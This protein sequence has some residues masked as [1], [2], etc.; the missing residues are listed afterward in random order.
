MKRNRFNKW[1]EIGFLFIV[2]GSCIKFSYHLY[3][4]LM[5]IGLTKGAITNV[6]F[7][8]IYNLK[9]ITT[10]EEYEVYILP[11][12]AISILLMI[13]LIELVVSYIKHSIQKKK[14]R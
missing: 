6:V 2:L 3:F 9:I 5:S 13:Y 8:N 10:L 1:T 4:V 7:N 11:T 12:Y 14:N